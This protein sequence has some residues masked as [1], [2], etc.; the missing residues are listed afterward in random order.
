MLALR[1]GAY[2]NISDAVNNHWAMTG[3]L[4]LRFGS[5]RLDL[6]A[7]GSFESET[8]R[9]REEFWERSEEGIRLTEKERKDQEERRARAEAAGQDFE[10]SRGRRPVRGR[11]RFFRHRVPYLSSRRPF[12]IDPADRRCNAANRRGPGRASG[13]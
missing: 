5:F 12:G 11:L 2:N 13:S 9:K 8:I 4:G 3:G 10:P 6:S 7:G 1:L